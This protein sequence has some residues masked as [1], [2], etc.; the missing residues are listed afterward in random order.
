MC[1]Q[2]VFRSKTTYYLKIQLAVMTQASKIMAVIRL[3]VV[4]TI[5]ELNDA[6]DFLWCYRSCCRAIMCV[7]I[8]K[9]LADQISNTAYHVRFLVGLRFSPS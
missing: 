4:L 6:L 3:Y 8:T 7:R 9:L 5:E 1:V 2:N